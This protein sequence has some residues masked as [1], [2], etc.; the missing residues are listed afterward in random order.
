MKGLIGASFS[1]PA[2]RLRF[3]VRGCSLP[4]IHGGGLKDR[5]ALPGT[6]VDF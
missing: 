3:T 1:I 2:F 6:G 4:A 5:E